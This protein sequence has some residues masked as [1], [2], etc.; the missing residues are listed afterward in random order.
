[1]T[2]TSSSSTSPLLT[3]PQG[4]AAVEGPI[5]FFD[6]VCGLCNAWVDFLL[7]HDRRGLWRFA[8]LQG[9]TARR[10][11]NAAD[12][13]HLHT[14][15]LWTPAGTYRKSSAVWR[16]LWSLGGVW[17][18]AACLTWLIPR[19]VRNWGYDLVARHRYRIFGRKESCRLPTPHERARFL[20]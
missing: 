12:V 10:L 6:G 16:I 4:P 14:L 8:P 5:V 15:V 9:E 18:V 11:L 2:G 13:E 17:R 3:A 20:D 1:M 19:P 7:K